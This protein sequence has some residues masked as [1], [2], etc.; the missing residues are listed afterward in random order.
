M[1]DK[2]DSNNLKFIK[3]Y[4]KYAIWAAIAVIWSYAL[5]T[6][7][8]GVSPIKVNPDFGSIGDYIGG[9]L[10]PIFG[11]LGLFA[12]LATIRLQNK[13]LK[14]S[15]TELKLTRKES[16][17]SA[18]ALKQQSNSIKLQNFENTFFNMINLHNEIVKSLKMDNQHWR[19][20]FT[21]NSDYK[22]FNSEYNE[23]KDSY[24]DLSHIFT[25]KEVLIELERR[26]KMVLGK[27]TVNLTTIEKNKRNTND[28][29]LVFYK[30]FQQYLSHY[31]RNIYQ[32]LNF[33]SNTNGINKKFYA[34]IF[35]SQLSEY[36]L[37]L[38][39]YNIVSD[40][41]KGIQSK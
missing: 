9:I 1:E 38:L 33:I 13:E 17:K 25:S 30:Q 23:N 8:Y 40:M 11:F 14:N 34:N 37:T 16:R 39:F 3:V 32:I 29:Y 18:K 19:I 41:G 5:I 27:A 36:E 15:S 24:K 10:N 6:V 26:L 35:R 21:L 7:M 28:R 20:N 22:N 4:K 31:F 12:L 2:K